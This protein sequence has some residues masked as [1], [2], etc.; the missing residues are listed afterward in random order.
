MASYVDML[1]IGARNAQNYA[2]LVEAGQ[3]KVPILLKRGFGCNVEEWLGAAEYILE[4]GNSSVV[5]CE[6]GIRTFEAATRFTLDLAA[7]PVIKRRS[8]LPVVVDPSHGTG[9][10]D[11]VAPMALAAAAAG[12]DG[13]L[14]DVHTEASDA[15]CDADQALSAADFH[16]LMDRLRLITPSLDRSLSRPADVWAL[17]RLPGS[18]AI[19]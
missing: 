7:I 15:R 9:S 12:A 8:H 10:R 6:R 3:A 18:S 5:M 17:S 2:L 16:R 11:L 19:D 13:I 14:V 1:Q 4:Q